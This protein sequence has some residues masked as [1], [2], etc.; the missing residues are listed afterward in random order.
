MLKVNY[1]KYIPIIILFLW[2]HICGAND[3]S[4]YFYEWGNIPSLQE[5]KQAAS[6]IRLENWKIQKSEGQWE[7]ISV[8]FFYTDVQSIHLKCT[9]SLA[10][11][12]ETGKARLISYGIRGISKIFLNG[13]LLH[14]QC[15]DYAP[16]KVELLENLLNKDKENEIEF[17]LQIPKTSDKGFPAY[18]HLFA[19]QNYLG[20]TRPLFISFEKTWDIHSLQARVKSISKK[21][22]MAYSY[23]INLPFKNEDR[24]KRLRIEETFSNK[25][26]KVLYKKIKGTNYERLNMSGEVNLP[27]KYLWSPDCPEQIFL[28]IKI[29]KGLYYLLHKTIPIRIRKLEVK[30]GKI[31]LNDQPVLIKGINYYENLPSMVNRNYYNTLLSDFSAIK[32]MGFNAIRLPR[33]LPDET[34]VHIADS[35][36]L[37]FFA[38]LPIWRYPLH[39]YLSDNLLENSKTTIQN[40]GLFFNNHPSLAAIGLGQEIPLHLAPVQKFML[41]LKGFVDSNLNALAYVSPIPGKPSSPEKITDFYMLDTY[42]SLY[43]FLELN[44]SETFPYTLAGKAAITENSNV[45]EWDKDPSIMERQVFLRREIKTILTHPKLQGGFVESFNDWK[46]AF[47]THLTINNSDKTIMPSGLYTFDHQPKHWIKNTG[48]V[49]DL[50]DTGTIKDPESNKKTNFFSIL[51]FFF[52]IV[53]FA[54]YRKRPRMRENLKRALKHPYGF[55]VDMRER[56]IVPLFNSFMINAYISIIVAAIVGSFVYYYSGSFGMQEILSIFF[57]PL[58][59]YN[60]YLSLSLSPFSITMIFFILF[61]IY[62]VIIGFILK[63]ISIFSTEKIRFRQGLAIGSWSGVPFMFLLPVSLISYNLYYYQQIKTYIIYLFIFFL[64]WTHLRIL[65]GI[66]VLFI[67]KYVKVLI[68]MVLSYIVP[69]IIFW[70]VFKP[71]PYWYE[72]LNLLFNAGNL[73]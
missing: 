18:V 5:S 41:I 56:R 23:Q 14:Y 16:F 21:V 60:N 70:A 58:G 28:N 66:R 8:P 54:I 9:F 11:V 15:N 20:I 3:G 51:V 29:K 64:L 30:K 24:F 63:V 53:F 65:N 32:N 69:L 59:I 35:L 39:L 34:M 33:Y 73:F 49:W 47:A 68:I 31:Q 62:P 50:G 71:E 2:F 67:T 72:Y 4:V 52:S 12:K 10:E 19:E 44:K 40:I 43:T 38:E 26:G 27:V 13:K 17:Y 42:H 7:D 22:T 55:F 6:N 36:G 57:I 46:A 45:F 37:L 61:L 1:K 25:E 48:D